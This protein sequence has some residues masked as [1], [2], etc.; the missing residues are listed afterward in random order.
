MGLVH[1]EKSIT[2]EDLWAAHEQRAGAF[3]AEALASTKAD[4]TAGDMLREGRAWSD[5]LFSSPPEAVGSALMLLLLAAASRR[6]PWVVT[7]TVKDLTR[8]RWSLSRADAFLAL[9]TTT[10]AAD[11][12]QAGWAFKTS[13]AILR[14][15]TVGTSL[16]DEET[17]VVR[18]AVTSLE[19]RQHL[20][21][22]ERREV[23]A[24]L[25]ALLPSVQS[26]TVDVSVIVP[27]DGWSVAV[28]PDLAGST[29]PDEVS[30]MLRH[31]ATAT[32]SKPSQTW[33]TGLG[34]ILQNA[35]AA[36]VVRVLLER[37]VSAE[38][39]VG[40]SRYGIRVPM[41]LNDQNADLAQ[42]AVWA[43]PL[44]EQPWLVP[45]LHR[46][47]IRGISQPGLIGWMSGDKVP[48]AAICVLGQLA[49][50]DA[51]V[52]LQQLAD[53][54]KHNGFRKRIAG[55]LAQAAQTAGITPSQRRPTAAGTWTAGA[56][57]TS[58]I[59]S[60]AGCHVD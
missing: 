36:R 41:V 26:G 25:V 1:G 32:G 21:S 52:A 27:G 29:S 17:S 47:A 39:V 57:T 12:W 33:L 23:R 16:T 28:L 24:R 11:D 9:A 20:P 37:L 59:P 46:L 43:G 49:G 31:L 8:R 13:E 10:R 54:T 58:N 15:A 35:E 3:V 45:T 5:R 44:I 30:T 53:S 42:A 6:L 48:N 22:P 18:A 50:P 34:K 38:P 4:A 51:V 60:P 14:R 40:L 2:G 19:G 7:M 55:A 56:A